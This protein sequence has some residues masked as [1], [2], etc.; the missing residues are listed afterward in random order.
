MTVVLNTVAAQ[1]EI[2]QRV[3]R[4]LV[5]QQGLRQLIDAFV[6]ERAVTEVEVVHTL[7]Q[8]RDGRSQ[9]RDPLVLDEVARQVQGDLRGK[10]HYHLLCWASLIFFRLFRR[11]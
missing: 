9:L 8:L 6:G 4:Q 3:G 1:V 7:R 11:F 2:R 5:Q 10:K